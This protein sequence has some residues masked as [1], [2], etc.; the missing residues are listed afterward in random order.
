MNIKGFKSCPKFCYDRKCGL[1]SSLKCGKVACRIEQRGV[2][3]SYADYRKGW[4]LV[5]NFY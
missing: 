1:D 4:N 3:R 5:K 2:K